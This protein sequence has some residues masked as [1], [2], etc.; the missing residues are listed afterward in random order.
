VEKVFHAQ[1]YRKIDQVSKHVTV[2]E[3]PERGFGRNDEHGERANQNR[4]SFEGWQYLI[5]PVSR[6][7]FAL[8]GYSLT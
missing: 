6:K 1:G 7:V 8:L 5:F 2:K 4:P 3:F